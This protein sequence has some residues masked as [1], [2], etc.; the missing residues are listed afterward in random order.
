[1]R[2]LGFGE[3]GFE[4]CTGDGVL[5]FSKQFDGFQSDRGVKV[6]EC[7]DEEWGAIFLD[8]LDFLRV[9]GEGVT[10]GIEEDIGCRME[11]QEV[12]FSVVGS[13]EGRACELV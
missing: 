9:E 7:E 10:E 2:V 12:V 11:E 4:G 5:E 13:D 6:L 1:M 3:L 8:K